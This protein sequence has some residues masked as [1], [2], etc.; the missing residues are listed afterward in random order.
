MNNVKVYQRQGGG[1]P[2][3]AAISIDRWWQNVFAGCAST[4]FHR[5]SGGIGLN[6]DA[7]QV[8]RAA[9]AFF[10][11]FD[12]FHAEPRP[13]ALSDRD[14]NEAYCLA[15]GSE[16]FAL[17]FPNGGAVR[18]AAGGQN[19]RMS[20]RW[21]DPNTAQF[22]SPVQLTAEDGTIS[23][24]SPAEARNADA[25]RGAGETHSPIWLAVVE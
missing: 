25:A 14:A 15:I 19:R 24:E 7:Q 23:L 4:R 5:P 17:Y 18:L 12:I 10:A 11:E 6:G 21:F 2:N 16:R 9:R 1:R 22:R 3:D 8:I 20:V 13:A